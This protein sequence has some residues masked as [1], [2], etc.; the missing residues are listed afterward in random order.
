MACRS[1]SSMLKL[2][3]GKR[4][5]GSL[6]NAICCA[7]ALAALNS[8]PACPQTPSPGAGFEVSLYER[9]IDL[10]GWRPISAGQEQQK[11]SKTLWRDHLRVKRLR[12]DATALVM[13]RAESDPEA[14]RPEISSSTHTLTVQEVK[15][16]MV[17]SARSF[18]RAYDLRLDVS[19]EAVGKAFD[20]NVDTVYWNAFSKGAGAVVGIPVQFET[21]FVQ[22][23]I[24][25]PNRKFERYDRIAFELVENAEKQVVED[26]NAVMTPDHTRIIWRIDDARL[27]WVY[28][29]HWQW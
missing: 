6:A 24:R 10:S 16:G 11:V 26:T 2:I 18:E 15:G 21:Q 27:N 22:L 28:A 3:T 8:Q 17:T 13:R 12:A 19:K 14:L 25:S 23:E 9:L 4:T 7:G 1:G 20:V 5:S 29:I